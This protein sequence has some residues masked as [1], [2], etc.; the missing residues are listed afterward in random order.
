MSQ[1]RLSNR[2]SRLTPSATTALG[3]K[4]A[5]LKAPGINVISF[6]AGEPDF[7]T[8]DALKAAGMK[9]IENQSNQVHPGRWPAELR[10]AIA[11]RVSGES[12]VRYTADQISVT[13]G[14]KEALFLAFLA[15]C[16][17]GDEVIIPAPYWVSYV[18]QSQNLGCQPGDCRNDSHKASVCRRHNSP[19]PS[20]RAP[21]YWYLIHHPILLGQ[22]IR[23]MI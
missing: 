20:L 6:G 1:V 3:G 5:A 10:K 7:A 14:A 4:I 23:Q 8:P 18:D 16:D 2:L 13:N 9:A 21:A 17:E 15:L 22:C 19:L 12:S 11:E